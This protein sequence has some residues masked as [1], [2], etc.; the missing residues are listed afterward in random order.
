MPELNTLAPKKWVDNYSGAAPTLTQ[1]ADGVKAGDIAIDSSQDPV[2][3][4]RCTDE[5]SP[6][7]VK[8]DLS[9]YLKLSGG[10]MSGDID[11]NGNDLLNIGNESLTFESGAKVSSN[12]RGDLNLDTE[13]NSQINVGNVLGRATVLEELISKQ[14]DGIYVGRNKIGE[15]GYELTEVGQEWKEVG[16]SSSWNDIAMSSD[17][18]YQTAVAFFGPVHISSDYGE[19]WTEVQSSA[20]WYSV[21]MSSDGKYQSAARHVSNIYISSDYGETWSPSSSGSYTWYSIAMSSDGK[22]QSACVS[23]GQIHISSDHGS[24][25][26][27]VED[28]KPWN[29]IVM[30]SS[31]KYQ[32]ATASARNIHISSDYGNTWSEVDSSRPWISVAMSSDGKY[33]S[34]CAYNLKIYVSHDYGNTWNPYG[35]N[36]QWSEISMSGDGRYQV[37]CVNNGGSIYISEDYGVTWSSLNFTATFWQSVCISNNGKY[38][39]AVSG[40]TGNIYISRSTEKRYGNLEIVGNI[41]ATSITSDIYTLETTSY[42]AGEYGIV[43]VDDDTAAGAVTITLPN[44]ASAVNKKYTIKKLGTTGNVTVETDSSET[45]DGSANLMISSQYESTTLVSDGSNWFI[46]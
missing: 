8:E 29:E 42:D 46:V 1:A 43:L 13:N 39:A 30:S 15:K 28:V 35:T 27:A 7:W 14:N 33:Q 38:L 6:V 22:Y 19:T 12:T 3:I 40:S 2:F 37:A 16:I 23:N 4:W 25:W 9:N 10:T 11:L 24:T 32:T 41:K 5:D 26:T 34:A 44:V 18:K 17:G 20:Q 21:A 36:E 31:G 45:I